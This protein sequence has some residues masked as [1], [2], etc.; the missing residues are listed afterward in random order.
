MLAAQERR[1]DE[2]RKECSDAN[3]RAQCLLTAQVEKI[4]SIVHAERDLREVAKRVL[5]ERVN[6]EVFL[7]QIVDRIRKVQL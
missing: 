7:N 1:I 3:Y 4:D 6:N 5:E 2:V